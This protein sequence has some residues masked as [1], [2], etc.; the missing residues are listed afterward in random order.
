MISGRLD[1][2]SWEG[3]NG[4]RRSRV[5][6]VVED[7]NFIGG[8]ARDNGGYNNNQP[9]TANNESA[10]FVPEDVPEDGI[11]LSEIPF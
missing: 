1:Q 6:I 5:E 10:E 4:E 3:P 9:A 11:D 2:R 7:F 8:T